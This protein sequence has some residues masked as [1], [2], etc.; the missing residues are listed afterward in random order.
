VT[1]ATTIAA[2][3]QLDPVTLEVI[4]NALPAIPNEMSADLRRASY[5]MMIYEV[6]DYCCALVAPNGDLVSQNAGGVSHF[7]ADLDVVVLD[8]I[9]QWGVDGLVPGD[10]LITNHQKVAGQHLNN[11]VISVPV[12]VSDKLVCFSMI[13]A[14]WVDVG[15]LSTGFGAAGAVADP[16][17]EGLQLDQLK[18]YEA[19]MPNQTLL[20]I[21]R[22][23]VR[24]PEA[25]LGDLRSQIAACQLGAR[26][27]EE[28]HAKYGTEVIST[29]TEQ[30]F[31]ESEQRCRNVVAGIPDGVYEASSFLDDDGRVRDEPVQIHARV[32]VSGSDMTIDLSGCSSQR[33]GAVN[34]RTRA[35]ALVAYKALTTPR[36]PVNAGAFRALQTVVPE[37]NIMMA[38]FPAP[39]S[40][41]SQPIPTVVDTIVKALAPAMVDR[42]P[43][44]HLGF[45]GGAVIFTGLDSET[46]RNFLVQSLEG[47]GWG[48]RPHEDGPSASLSVC[49]GDVR[50]API[51]T[52]EL[53]C[54]VVIEERKLR[55]DSGGA[56]KHRGGFGIDLMVRNLMPGKWNLSQ[57]RRRR[58]PPWGLWGGKPGT[59]PDYLL[60]TPADRDFRSVDVVL[61][62]VPASTYALIRTAG[63]GGWGD[64]NERDPAA[65][66]H[67]VLEGLV[68]VEAAENDYGVVIVD[69]ELDEL[70]SARLRAKRARATQGARSIPG[71]PS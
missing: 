41:W 2:E 5:N 18:V 68:S 12:F 35:G 56:G 27:L 1:L 20:K 65:V 24:F 46:G 25:S 61:H 43:A 38:T 34:S 67:D 45:L 11:V 9:E 23:N 30:I 44:A 19:G 53:R 28:L 51:E 39:M 36:E 58:C 14:H 10:V 71:D 42:A 69:G 17:M 62:E 31:R 37:G 49:Q 22:A 15:G 21:L 70:A 55:P 8:A 16:W 50:N 3:G 6:G 57:P 59:P 4:R 66:L 13:R 32:T 54:P 60:R 63:G 7:V 47:G 52:I 29:A 40:D 33:L 64:P 26:R 48:G